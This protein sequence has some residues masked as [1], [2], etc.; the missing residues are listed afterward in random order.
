[1]EPWILLSTKKSWRTISGHL[2]VTSSWSE[3]G[4]CS[5]TMIQNTPANPPL[6]GWRKT[7]WRLWSGLVKVLTWI[8]LRCCGM[9]LKR[10]FM[11]ENPPMWLNYN[12]SAKMSGPKFLHSA[13]TDSL[14]VIANAWWQLLPL[15]VAQPVICQGSV[16]CVMCSRLL[17]P[18]LVCFLSSSDVIIIRVNSCPAVFV[19][20]SVINLCIL[21]H[22]CSVRFHLVYSLLPGVSCL[23]VI[24]Y[25]YLSLRPR[26]RVPVP[27]SCVHRDI[28]RFRG[29]ALFH[30]GP[31]GFGF[32]FPFI[33]KNFIQKLH[34]VLTC[35]IFD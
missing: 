33:I 14:Q 35:V 3:L 23:D 13:V 34:V 20:L 9:T 26:L 24:K 25:Y 28:I 8:L 21:V 27:P 1:M 22:A 19:S 5:R 6:N 17:C 32:C 30:T 18:Y 11:L 7:K 12:N 4:F 31:C 2:F 15:R 29:Q 16:L 10:R